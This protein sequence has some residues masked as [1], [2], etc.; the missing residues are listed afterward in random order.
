MHLKA[1][2]VQEKGYI[3]TA[4]IPIFWCTDSTK[5]S[6]IRVPKLADRG[7]PT[8]I[9]PQFPTRSTISPLN[10]NRPTRRPSRPFQEP[11]RKS[12]EGVVR[13]WEGDLRAHGSNQ[14]LADKTESAPQARSRHATSRWPAGRSVLPS[15]AACQSLVLIW[16]IRPWP[17]KATPAFRGYFISSCI[18]ALLARTRST[19]VGNCRVGFVVV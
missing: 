9:E 18:A 1:F 15:P 11:G 5:G 14:R 3:C 2:S 12:K 6:T 8:L 4:L 17:K 7:Q 13:P 16:T 10:P 19:D